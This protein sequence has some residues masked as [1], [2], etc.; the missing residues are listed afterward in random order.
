MQNVI[1]FEPS[2]PGKFNWDTI[3][4]VAVFHIVAVSALFTFSWSNLLAAFIT[5]WVAASWGIG[6]GYHRLLTHRGF[7]SPRWLERVLATFGTLGI[8]L[9][10]I[11]I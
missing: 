8:Q 1:E 6:I 3:I 11:H 9:S 5:W 2:K 7:K 10:L 4:F